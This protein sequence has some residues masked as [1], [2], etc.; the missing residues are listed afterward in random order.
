MIE[1]NQL[2]FVVLIESNQ[3]SIGIGLRKKERYFAQNIAIIV[4]FAMI[5]YKFFRSSKIHI[6]SL[7]G[8]I[9]IISQL[10][11]EYFLNSQNIL[12]ILDQKQPKQLKVIN[13]VLKHGL[14]GHAFL[15]SRNGKSGIFRLRDKFLF[16]LK[17]K[18]QFLT[19]NVAL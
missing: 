8:K 6:F 4:T 17:N 15:S 11:G 13:Y 16:L 2:A 18:L 10:P 5:F 9:W 12:W 1:K 14:M 19:E 3:E 7:Q